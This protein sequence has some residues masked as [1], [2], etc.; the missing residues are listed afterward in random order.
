MKYINFNISLIFAIAFFSLFMSCNME[1]EVKKELSFTNY[2][3]GENIHLFNNTNYPAFSLDMKYLSPNDSITYDGLYEIMARTFFDSSYISNKNII[4]LMQKS[5]DELIANYRLLEVEIQQ[6]S[7]N[8]GLGYNWEIIKA[9]DIVYKG[10]KYISFMNET[11]V[12]SGGAHGNTNRDYHVFSLESNSLITANELFKSDSCET[13]I[14]LQKASLTKAGIALDQLYADGFSCT[15][16][17]YII[18][19]GIIFHYDQYEIASYADG[20]MSIFI[21]FE[22]IQPHIKLLDIIDEKKE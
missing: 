1:Q 4:E 22:D 10:K 7:M 11:F 6:D 9:N 2:T 15:N 12:Y 14:E 5:A 13:I 3:H 16:N 20:P 21:S 19:K 17:F 8:I 18:D